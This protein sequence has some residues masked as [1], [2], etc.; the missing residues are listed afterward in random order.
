MLYSY[1]YLIYITYGYNFNEQKIKIYVF[2]EFPLLQQYNMKFFFYTWTKSVMT[3]IIIHFFLLKVTVKCK[4]KQYC[5]CFFKAVCS[6]SWV[7]SVTIGSFAK[8]GL[9]VL[10]F[11]KS[12]R[13][14][15]YCKN[16]MKIINKTVKKCRFQIVLLVH[17]A[18]KFKSEIPL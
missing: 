9:D 4:S 6:P 16:I 5:V 2:Q 8:L 15:C 10:F 3:F 17:S 14:T 18:I 12:K 11:V 13:H 1:I 7:V